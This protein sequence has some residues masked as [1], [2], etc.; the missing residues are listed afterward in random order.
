M[1]NSTSKKITVVS[2]SFKSSKHLNRLFSNLVNKANHPDEL[3]FLVVDNTNGEDD[4]LKESFSK[5]LDLTII[6]NNGVGL[7]RSISHSFALDVGLKNIDTKFT[8]LVDPDIHVFKKGWDSFCL[9]KIEMN[10]NSVLGAP[11]PVWKLGKVHDYPSVVFMFFNTQIV[12]SFEKSFYPFPGNL[13]H[14]WNS[15]FRKMVRLGGFANK[16]RL[17]QF[18]SL[19]TFCGCLESL[20]GITAPDTGKGIIDS[21]RSYH[22]QSLTFETPYPN[23]FL[24]KSQEVYLEMAR[25][26]EI[27][28][29]EKAPFLT[30]MY[31]SGVF[32]WKSA[33]SSDINHWQTLID[34]IENNLSS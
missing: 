26:Y 29:H 8:C 25:E 27:Y 31:S 9:A 12:Q 3:K 1:S 19:R 20:T 21:F 13:R 34:Q 24:L 15:V 18:K 5:E 22:F 33:K 10:E 17:N 32:H 6:P 2:V 23:D 14:L 16:K 28:F 4:V 7:Q 11:Y 30:H